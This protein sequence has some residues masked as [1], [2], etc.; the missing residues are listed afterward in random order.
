VPRFSD[1]EMD[2]L[3]VRVPGLYQ[4]LLERERRRRAQADP[5]N[6]LSDDPGDLRPVY[7]RTRRLLDALEAGLPVVMVRWMVGSRRSTPAVD[8]RGIGSR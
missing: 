7:R 8:L 1:G 4:A 2:G 6:I 5:R 3:G